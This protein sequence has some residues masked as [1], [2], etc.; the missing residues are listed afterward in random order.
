LRR[1]FRAR[2]QP[3]VINYS[4]NGNGKNERKLLLIKNE[5]RSVRSERFRLHRW[6]EL[7]ITYD[8]LVIAVM[9]VIVVSIMRVILIVPV[10]IGVPAVSFHVPPPMR[11]R[12]A[13][14]PRVV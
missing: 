2:R 7:V 6:A 12:P 8:L 9:V 5:K 14:F 1:C 10:A 3:A 13:V 11:V 4:F